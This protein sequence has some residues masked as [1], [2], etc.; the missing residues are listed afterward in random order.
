[1][2]IQQRET[3]EDRG[4]QRVESFCSELILGRKKKSLPRIYWSEWSDR[5]E[6]IG[7]ERER[8]IKRERKKEKAE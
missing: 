6:I 7:R 8:E 4:H 1:M 5:N 3:A 2:I